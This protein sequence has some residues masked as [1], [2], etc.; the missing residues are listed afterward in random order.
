MLDNEHDLIL[1]GRNKRIT[2][3][4][5][6]RFIWRQVADALRGLATT[7]DHYSRLPETPDLPEVMMHRWVGTQIDRT[8]LIIKAA[9]EQAGIEIQEGR[10]PG[11][12]TAEHPHDERGTTSPL[13]NR[14]LP[15]IV[16]RKY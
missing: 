7:L 1:G 9:A 12:K 8:N 15:Y 13:D 2:I 10:R 16:N 5:Q 6:D 4:M 11:Q 3:P 14:K